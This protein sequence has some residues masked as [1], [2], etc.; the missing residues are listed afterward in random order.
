M[1][2]HSPSCTDVLIESQNVVWYVDHL[3]SIP[4]FYRNE[5]VDR[6]RVCLLAQFNCLLW[7]RVRDL[8]LFS[9][10]A[11][12][13]ITLLY[14]PNLAVDTLKKLS[15]E[16]C[17]C[18]VTFQHFKLSLRLNFTRQRSERQFWQLIFINFD[19]LVDISQ[20]TN[21]VSLFVGFWDYMS[22]V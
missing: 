11:S 2:N 10:C 15:I 6:V 17:F 20:L 19:C 21:L 12:S 22:F 16:S 1:N 18:R 7:S 9:S 8:V 4:D 14:S 5:R 13:R 3:I